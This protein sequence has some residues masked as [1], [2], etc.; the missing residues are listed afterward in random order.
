[1]T[2][3]SQK[4]ASRQ[5]ILSTAAQQ[6]RDQGYTAT[7][8]SALMAKSELTNGAFYAHFESKEDLLRHTLLAAG[9]QMG[10]QWVSGL[11]ELSPIERL[12]KLLA[13][14]LGATHRDQ[15]AL[16]CTVPTLGAEIARQDDS[17][18]LAFEQQAYRN[19][20][21]MI[22]DLAVMGVDDAVQ[23]AWVLLSLC[24]G[25]ITLSRAV[26]DE[27]LKDQLLDNAL[28]QSQ[29]LLSTWCGEQVK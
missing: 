19:L 11:E 26:H 28:Q 17:V 8:I 9:Q 15:P 21:P 27:T 6:F 23:C 20:Q 16:G 4:N 3:Q 7:G 5:R 12:P 1:M 13:R 25:A 2:R 22:D 14:Y 18:K 29:H 24:V 10:E